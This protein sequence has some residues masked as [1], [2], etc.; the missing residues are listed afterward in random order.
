MKRNRWQGA[1]SELLPRAA[2]ARYV[3]NDPQ[4]QERSLS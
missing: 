4:Q 1:G 2:V 3:I